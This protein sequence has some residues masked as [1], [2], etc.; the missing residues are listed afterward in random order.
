MDGGL[1]MALF[2]VIKTEQ[3]VMEIEASSAE[4]ARQRAYSLPNDDVAVDE[5]ETVS[6]RV[7]C[8]IGRVKPDD[9]TRYI[10]AQ[11]GDDAY[12]QIACTCG[13]CPDREAAYAWLDEL[14]EQHADAGDAGG[15]RDWYDV[16]RSEGYALPGKLW[17]Y[18]EEEMRV[19]LQHDVEAAERRAGWP[20]P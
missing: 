9:C 13:E 4:E 18:I 1:I 8:I 10:A 7:Q 15:E 16:V 6:V 11:H 12:V 19:W 3:V 2:Q 17:R 20:T 14:G 5:I